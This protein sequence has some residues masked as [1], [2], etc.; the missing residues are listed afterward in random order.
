MTNLAAMKRRVFERLN[1]LA[2]DTSRAADIFAPE[3]AWHGQHPVNDGVGREVWVRAALAPLIDA[4]PD[5]ERR[6]DILNLGV[7]DGAIW[8][9]A[10]GHYCGTFVKPLFGIP[11]TGHLAFL[12]YGE[13]YRVDESGTVLEVVTLWDLIGLMQQAGV[14]PLPP[15]AGVSILTPG[16]RGHDGVRPD[17]VEPDAG[18]RSL[19]LVMAMAAGL[20]EY[21]GKTLQSM[22][23]TRF[24]SP[25]MLWYGPAGIGANRRLKGFED[26]HQ[27]PFLIAF[28]DRRGAPNK[29]RIGDGAYCASRGW[30]SL[31][32]THAGPYLGH[33]ATNRA[34]TMRVMD[35]WR[36]DGD[37]LAE[38]WVFIDLPHLFLQFGRDLMASLPRRAG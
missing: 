8:I 21:D 25:D 36:R 9:A 5:V 28:P 17:V 12:R 3:L 32:M 29:V 34:V 27:R 35:W 15:A 33:P 38:N 13:F 2:R 14:D 16:P 7:L 10:M 4:M 30:P 37:L 19:A 24:W 31:L 6:D 11:A 18:A 22:G 1:G 23:Q 26:F 20:G